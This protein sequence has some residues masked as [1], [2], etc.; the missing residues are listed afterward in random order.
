MRVKHGYP[1]LL[2]LASVLPE[3]PYIRLS[4]IERG[5]AVA[6]ADEIKRIAGLL[7]VEPRELVLDVDDPNFDVAA[8]AE[9]F[10][11]GKTADKAEQVFAVLLAAATRARRLRSAELTIA[12]IERDYGIPPVILSRIE[13]AAKTLDRWNDATV[14]RI[15]R[16]FDVADARSLR[17]LVE[18]QYR[19]GLLDEYVGLIADPEIRIQKTRTHISRLL[20]EIG[21]LAASSGPSVELRSERDSRASQST[22][23]PIKPR[24]RP[25]LA[26]PRLR[27]LRLVPVIGAP[28]PGGLISATE[29][30]LSVEAPGAAGP[31]AFGLKICRPTL[32]AGLPG[33]SIMIVDP[34]I[35]PSA[36]GLAAVRLDGNFRL[37]AVTF[38]LNGAMIGHSLNPKLEIPLDELDPS[39][40]M[41]VIGASFV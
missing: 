32:G 26:E 22:D 29:T 38:D 34:E 16:L 39:D 7:G 1:K 17:H 37:L 19:Q 9:P 8:W 11:D 41:A 15:C 23:H 3:I 13:N 20:E 33:S 10:A 6:R 27:P 12:I 24:G 4:K 30:N 18:E 14:G 28:L 25:A 2:S 35:F 5:E 31:K 36:G 40:V 21:A